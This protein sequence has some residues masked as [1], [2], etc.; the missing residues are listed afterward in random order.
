MLPPQPPPPPWQIGI[1]YWKKPEKN[2]ILLMTQFI[3][4]KTS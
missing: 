4:G 2:E 1:P 3:G